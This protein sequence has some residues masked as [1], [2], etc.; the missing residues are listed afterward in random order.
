M[1]LRSGTTSSPSNR[2]RDPDEERGATRVSED[3]VAAALGLLIVTAVYLDGRAHI[4]GLPD[5]FFTPWHAFLYGDLLLLVGW[6]AVLGR[7]A[8]VRLRLDRLAIIPAGY[9]QSVAGAALFAAGGVAD[10]IWHQLFGVE[11]GIDALLSP[12]HLALFA[13]GALLFSGPIRA[14]QMRSEAS[15]PWTGL[16]AVLAVTAIAAVAAFALIYLSGFLSDQATFAVSQAPEGTAEHITS[17][18]LASAGLA[19]YLVTSLVIVIPLTFL[20]RQRLALPGAATFLVLSL[21]LLACVLEDFRNPGIIIAAAVAGVLAD[22]ALY[23]LARHSSSMRGRELVMAALVPL[24]LWSGQLLALAAQG[25]ILWS[26]EM[27]T[28]VVIASAGMSFTAVFVL[29]FAW[30]DPAQLPEKAV[31]SGTAGET[32]TGG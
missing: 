5:S 25:P 32:L 8:A 17:E 12:T 19:S 10:M 26:L 20:I 6:L 18:A 7:R 21:A 28:G 15:L 27:V 9:G 2:D 4:L 29:R 14:T 24:L 11:S 13:G 23:A 3:L 31:G 1:K 22:L 16:P 30:S